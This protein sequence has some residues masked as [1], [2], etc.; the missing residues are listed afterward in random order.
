MHQSKAYLDFGSTP[1]AYSRGGMIMVVRLVIFSVMCLASPAHAELYEFT[2]KATVSSSSFP[3]V[4]V[5]AP[6]E[7]RYF[8]DTFDRSPLPTYGDYLT[9]SQRVKLPELTL[10]GEGGNL[11]VNRT[12]TFDALASNTAALGSNGTSYALRMVI[13]FQPRVFQDDR[14]LLEWPAPPPNV[15]IVDFGF[16]NPRVVAQINS[17]SSALVPELSSLSAIVLGLFLIHRWCRRIIWVGVFA[18]GLFPPGRADEA[19]KQCHA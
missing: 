10:V 7:M 4:Q 8:G 18:K 2:V 12:D 9:F 3:F 13:L 17:Y 14:L 16:A 15:A 5:G 11:Y 1:N 19:H 6:L